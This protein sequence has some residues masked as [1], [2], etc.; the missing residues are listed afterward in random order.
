MYNISR[1]HP[2][3]ESLR[4]REM[5]SQSLE[6]GLLV[7]QGLIAY[8]RGEAFDYLFGER[9]IPAARNAIRAAA[10]Q[11]ILADRP[12]I[13]V[14]GNVASVAAKGV[15][16][17]SKITGADVEINLFY[18][19]QERIRKI[20]GVLRDAGIRNVLGVDPAYQKRIPELCSERRR[21]D[22]RGIMK[23]DVVVIPLE[24]GDRTE[25]LRKMGKLVIAV[26][27]NP[28]SRTSQSA[29][30]SI[31]DDIVR[32]IPHMIDQIRY[33]N[34]LTD[35][36]IHHIASSFDNSANLGSVL[37]YLAH[38]ISRLSTKRQEKS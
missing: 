13:S 24:D 20:S 30:I 8:G 33:L 17:L 5:L 34:R 25:S 31:V 23:A 4:S 18:R 15:A 21:V 19:S 35:E 27:L 29:S 26:D 9:T 36:E 1:L 11:I 37:S 12:V 2:R 10:A 28:L 7:P 14:N 6:R 22:S 32:V 16:T 3:A 38:R